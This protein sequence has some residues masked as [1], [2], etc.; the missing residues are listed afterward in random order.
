MSIKHSDFPLRYFDITRGY[1]TSTIH[2]HQELTTSAGFDDQ[3]D[4]PCFQGLEVKPQALFFLCPE[5]GDVISMGKIW[6][7][8]HEQADMEVSAS[9][10]NRKMVRYIYIYITDIHT[11]H[12]ST[13][14]YITV[15]YIALHCIA[16]HSITVHC[17]ALHYITLHYITLHYRHTYIYSS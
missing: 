1:Y 12:Y 8:D 9:R 17:I 15:H 16:L 10:T 5:I 14:Q 2:D 13:L 4:I 6:N 11:L 7:C 3:A